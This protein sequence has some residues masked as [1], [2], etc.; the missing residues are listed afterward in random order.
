MTFFFK[1]KEAALE[2]GL[3]TTEDNNK[4][5]EKNANEAHAEPEEEILTTGIQK[6]KF[7]VEKDK[8]CLDL[9]S[10]V[11]NI[12]RERQLFEHKMID[13]NTR[14]NECQKKGE[15]FQRNIESL[16]KAIEDRERRISSLE[17]QLKEKSLHIDQIMDDYLHLQSSSSDSIRDLNNEISIREKKF[18]DYLKRTELEEA[19]TNTKIKQLEARIIELEAEKDSFRNMYENI[20]K[21]NKYLLNIT[22][23][24]T[25]RMSTSMT[26]YSIE[27]E[28]KQNP[29]DE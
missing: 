13:A 27:E 23:D 22:N 1:K 8:T 28:K 25:N 2:E 18:Q 11:E 10:A 29:H 5:F 19:R 21:E 12:V 16:Y 7:S 4:A 6:S 14:L 3:Y 17:E 20:R 9:I 24:F 15:T 26:K